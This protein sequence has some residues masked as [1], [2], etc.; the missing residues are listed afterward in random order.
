MHQM[1]SRYIKKS[2]VIA[3]VL[4]GIVAVYNPASASPCCEEWKKYFPEL[5]GADFDLLN[6]AAHVKLDE[7][8]VGAL[9]SWA[10]GDTGNSGTVQFI[11]RYT[12]EN[13]E[14][15]K[16]WHT[17]TSQPYE[18]EVWE[19][20]SCKVRETWVLNQPPKRL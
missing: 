9:K 19:V 2:S 6:Q 10:N 12:S 17:M 18:G 16:L 7:A 15:R 4:A 13:T 20:N 3:V 1:V 8:P 11:L 14:C 5:S